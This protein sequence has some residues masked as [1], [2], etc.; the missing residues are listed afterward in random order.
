MKGRWLPEK[1]GSEDEDSLEGSAED[2][3]A[4]DRVIPYVKDRR[5]ILVHRWSEKLTLQQQ[6]S[7][8]FAL[9]RGI[10]VAFHLED[11]E[12]SSELLPHGDTKDRLLLVEA[13]EGG[14]G[15]L[16]RLVS[17]RSA[18]HQ[19]ARA[20]LDM[21]HV[22]PDT[23]EEHESACVRGCY[24]CLLSYGNQTSQE[25]IDRRLA[26]PLLQRLL[27]AELRED[28]APHLPAQTDTARAN[29]REALPAHASAAALARLLRRHGLRVPDQ[30]DAVVHGVRVDLH[31]PQSASVVVVDDGRDTSALLFAGINVV[32]LPPEG[33]PFDVVTAHPSVFGV[34]ERR[35]TPEGQPR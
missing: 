4:K 7:L 22:D 14:A 18:L 5:N 20:A 21:L 32:H 16:R 27:T 10:E 30:V 12:L 1:E 25:H 9:E 34:L 35:L 28:A 26:V 15:V 29:E 8:Q 33:D 13:A 23:G 17:D 3:K 31:Y 11:S 2:V 24:R 19:V 6:V